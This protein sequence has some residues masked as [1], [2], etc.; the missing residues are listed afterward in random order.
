MTTSPI[1]IALVVGSTRDA[2]TSRTVAGWFAQLAKER[3]DVELDVLDLADFPLSTSGPNWQPGQAELDVLARS[4]SRLAE[5]EAFVVVTPEYNRSF[6]AVLKNF[7]DWHLTEWRAKPVGFV[8]HGG[9]LSAGLRAVEQLRLVFS[10]LRTV[11]MRDSVS[12]QGGAAAFDEHGQPRQ[13]AESAAA[14]TILL[15][16][17]TW[18]AF[19]L[20]QARDFR[21][22][23]A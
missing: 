13:A 14:V 3:D 7:I 15:D 6:P 21:P 8:S 17:L 23:P 11:T 12:F 2:C 5:A 22:Y 20:R 1:R 18:W 16:E 10:E 9:G 4:G 19:A